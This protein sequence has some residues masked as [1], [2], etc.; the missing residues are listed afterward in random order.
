MSRYYL[1]MPQTTYEKILPQI[2]DKS[3]AS[4]TGMKDNPKFRQADKD[5]FKKCKRAYGLNDFE[6]TYPKNKAGTEAIVEIELD[7]RDLDEA[8]FTKAELDSVKD[9]DGN[10]DYVALEHLKLNKDKQAGIITDFGIWKSPDEV[11]YPTIYKKL[12]DKKKQIGEG[13]YRMLYRLIPETSAPEQLNPS[14]EVNHENN[15]N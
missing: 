7:G 2:P 12:E 8:D 9:K 10:I 4:E 14:E 6:S 15:C 1:F 11:K 13:N 3:K 5:R